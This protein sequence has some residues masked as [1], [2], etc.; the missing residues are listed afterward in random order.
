MASAFAGRRQ[1]VLIE[2][3]AGLGRTRVLD[4]CV[5]EAK[6]ARRQRAA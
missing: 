1:S 2:A 3:A 6:N 4:Q 5:L